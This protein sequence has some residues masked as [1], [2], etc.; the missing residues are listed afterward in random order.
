MA[1]GKWDSTIEFVR[2][3]RRMVAAAGRRVAKADTDE[4]AEL[5]AL[6]EGV[7]DA[8]AVAL[9]GMKH[10]GY[11]W[12]ELGEVMGTTGQAVNMRYG[13]R[14]RELLDAMEAEETA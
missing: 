10:T 1:K 9:A 5:V 4:L 11:S 2:M 7:E 6:R 8:I 12:A 13:P 3:T 14:V